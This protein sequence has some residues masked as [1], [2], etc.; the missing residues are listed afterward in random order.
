MYAYQVP[1]EPANSQTSMGSAMKY[2]EI[3]NSWYKNIDDMKSNTVSWVQE[4]T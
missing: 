4:T 1:G 3:R 2:D